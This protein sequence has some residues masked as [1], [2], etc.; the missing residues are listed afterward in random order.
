MGSLVG[1]RFCASTKLRNYAAISILK[2]M[3]N[4]PHYCYSSNKGIH[5]LHNQQ[6]SLQIIQCCRILN[7]SHCNCIKASDARDFSTTSVLGKSKNRGEKKTKI[8]RIDYNEFEQVVDVNKLVSQFDK[9]IEKL[10][11]DFTQHLS[12]RSNTGAIETLPI[13]FEGNDYTL[14]E[15]AQISRK[16][17][18]IVLNVSTFPQAIPNILKSLTE[19]QMNLN[20]QQDGT[21]IYIPVPKVTK[22]HRQILSKNA[23]SFYVKCCD[24]IRDIRNK[25]IKKIRQKE[26]LAKD[27]VFRIEN[28]VD[29]L[30]HQY[31]SKAEQMLETKQKE[32][33]GDAE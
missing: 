14:Q 30:N 22:E 32:L 12:I 28:Y 19:N 33:V 17:K 6:R 7:L 21:T 4:Y 24:S 2:P 23:K 10:K 31:V 15:L 3:K 5:C 26:E 11:D 29:I 16:P 1:I 25:Q 8:Q 13:K 20:P 27:L 18:L 9:T